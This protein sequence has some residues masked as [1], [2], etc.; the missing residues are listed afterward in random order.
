MRIALLLN[1]TLFFNPKDFFNI[2]GRT[3][4]YLFGWVF[5]FGEKKISGRKNIF[6]G[7]QMVDKNNGGQEVDKM[8]R[9]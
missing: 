5:Y 6:D 4:G 3:P 8:P 2:S 9:K 1:V 7:G